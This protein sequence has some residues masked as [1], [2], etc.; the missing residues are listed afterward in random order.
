MS[1]RK[2]LSFDLIKVHVKA[3]RPL[4][5]NKHTHRNNRE[6]PTAKSSEGFLFTCAIIRAVTLL[7][8]TRYD[9]TK[10]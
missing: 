7:S 3:R 4:L 5:M 8:M 1:F 2:V 9:L 6:D 10:S